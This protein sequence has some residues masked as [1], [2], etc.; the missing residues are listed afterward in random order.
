MIGGGKGLWQAP[1]IGGRG[2]AAL[3]GGI[4]PWMW[5]NDMAVEGLSRAD[6]DVDGRL[7]D[8]SSRANGSTTVSLHVC[9]MLMLLVYL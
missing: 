7:L 9:T 6:G 8:M 5:R 3:G 2:L 4:E 1:I